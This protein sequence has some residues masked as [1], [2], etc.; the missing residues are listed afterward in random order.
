MNK[1]HNIFL[2]L[3]WFMFHTF[4]LALEIVFPCLIQVWNLEVLPTCKHLPFTERKI[5]WSIVTSSIEGKSLILRLRLKEWGL[6]V[7]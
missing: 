7:L 3:Q 2:Q 4:V 5:I 1:N 6:R